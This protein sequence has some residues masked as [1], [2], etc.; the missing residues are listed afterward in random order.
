M[1]SLAALQTEELLKLLGEG[2]L[3]IATSIGT[4]ILA[5]EDYEDAVKAATG[6]T[7]AAETAME[8]LEGFALGTS[9]TLE[10]VTAAFVEL[11]TNGLEASFDALKSYGNVAAGLN[12]TMKETG[13]GC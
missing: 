3:A 9:V 2:I 5:F 7:A 6:T 12:L 10:D 1:P 8:M 4:A 13:R 11:R